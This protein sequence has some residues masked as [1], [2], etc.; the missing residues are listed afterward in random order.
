MKAILDK[1][2]YIYILRHIKFID[3]IRSYTNNNIFNFSSYEKYI[4]TK[5]SYTCV[6]IGDVMHIYI[7]MNI[8]ALHLPIVL[9]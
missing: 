2:I 6:S 8:Y 1:Y 5:S 9:N 7:H 3:N 4:I